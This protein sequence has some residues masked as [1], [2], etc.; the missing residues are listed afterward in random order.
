MQQAGA[1]NPEDAYRLYQ[2]KIKLD[3]QGNVVAWDGG[4]AHGINDFAASLKILIA[5]G[6]ISSTG[7]V[8][9]ECRQ[10]EPLP[11]AQVRQTRT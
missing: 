10:L 6:R 2:D 4:V 1:I 3:E 8:P 5:A 7:L 11:K 9:V